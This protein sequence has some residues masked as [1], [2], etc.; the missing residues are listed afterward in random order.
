LNNKL[1]KSIRR[2]KA[3]NFILFTMN[4]TSNVNFYTIMNCYCHFQQAC[5][6]TQALFFMVVA[7]TRIQCL[8]MRLPAP[9][10]T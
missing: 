6:Q 4:N 3:G 10:A 8:C 1:D 5:Y 2:G 7:Q 9:A